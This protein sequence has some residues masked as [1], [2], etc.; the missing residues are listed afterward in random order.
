MKNNKIVNE[1]KW[2][3]KIKD[4]LQ[5]AEPNERLSKSYLE[6]SKS[7]LARAEKDFQD[8]DLLWATVVIYYSEYYALY[9]FLQRIGI[10]CENH[11][12]SILTVTF[13]LGE[14]KTKIINEHKDKR[15]D[16][17]YYMK[18]GKEKQVEIMLKEAKEFASIF[19]GIVSNMNEDEINSYREK[20]SRILK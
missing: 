7:S 1:L 13:L 15:I 4:G 16:A 8:G 20:I 17:Q 3:C 11:Y 2:C 18:V 12:C 19:D 9:S 14:E 10:K 6:E 5:I